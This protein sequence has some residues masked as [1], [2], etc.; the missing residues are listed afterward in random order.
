MAE[1]KPK[2]KKNAESISN[3]GWRFFFGEYI[4][5]R[6]FLNH[7]VSVVLIV[8]VLLCYINSGY[9]MKTKREQIKSLKRELSIVRSESIRQ[10]SLYNSRTRE[11]AMTLLVD[12]L[13][14]GLMAQKQPPYTLHLQPK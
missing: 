13:G 9:V 12:S 6:L 11:S 4:P 8:V 3:Y 2:S 10:Q 14:L 1:K 5:S 7:K